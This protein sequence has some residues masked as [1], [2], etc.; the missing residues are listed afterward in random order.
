MAPSHIVGSLLLLGGTAWADIYSR[1]AASASCNETYNSHSIPGC[2]TAFGFPDCV[3]GP[4][5]NNTVCDTTAYE[6]IN[7]T[8][9]VN[10]AIPRLGLPAYQWWQEALHG[11]AFSFPDGPFSY[12]GNYSS[13]TSF[14]QPILMGA[15]FDDTLIR[16]VATVV[17]TEARAFSNALR[18]G[19]DYWT[20]NINPFK[21]PRWGRGQETPGEDPFHISKYVQELVYGLQGGTDPKYK[22]VVATCKHFVGYDLEAADGVTRRHE[23]NAQISQQDLSEYYTP[24]FQSCVRDSNVGAVMCSYNSVNGVP[25]CASSYFL[26]TILRDH[27]NW[28]AEQQWV[29][30]DCDAV[31]DIWDT[32]NYTSSPEQAAADA[33]NA[34]TGAFD[35]GLFKEATI[36]QALTRLYSSLVRLGYFDPAEV[37]PYRSLGWSD[38]NTPYA[39]ELAL[40]AAQEGIVLLKNDGVLPLNIG[41]GTTVAMLGNWTNATTQMQGNYAGFAPYLISP[42]NATKQLGAQMTNDPSAAD[43][44]IFAGGIDNNI[45]AESLDRLNITWPADQ[46]QTISDLA[47]YGKPMVVLQMGGGQVDSSF[48]K[49]NSNISALV[50]GGYPGQSGGVALLDVL[51]GK[52]AP[53]G[54][55]PLT[56]YPGEYVDEVNMTDM[57]LRPSSTSP[58][59]TYKWYTGVPV[60]EFGYGLHYTNFT[61]DIQDLSSLTYN[62]SDIVSTCQKTDT[63]YLDL[64]TLGDELR[65]NVKNV[66]STTS[67]YVA[68]VFAKGT[69][70]PSPYPNKSL[71]S[72]TRLFDIAPNSTASTEL[73]LTLGALSRA[74][75][76]GNKIL[77]PGQYTLELDLEPLSSVNF[78]LTGEAMTLEDWPQA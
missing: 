41:A 68:L 52:V 33:L 49:N 22:R 15:A 1:Q 8:V 61:A 50:W 62:I 27:W 76:N 31:E 75:E 71:V 14:P 43:V 57:S 55:L 67:D 47:T 44:I 77:Y 70:G 38:V 74:D 48:I 4:L 59:R 73:T 39:Q 65:V 64:C 16:D 53:A 23:F 20:P 25:T 21:D 3:N 32:H 46:I 10:P 35:Q 69:Y 5:S 63:R 42:W 51:T 56:Q 13:A 29:T 11:V 24:S 26:Q 66:G 30:S 9:N 7:L 34:G 12:S 36:D 17:S 6:K 58:G 54:R 78:T 28:T 2:S 37:Q 45:E 40:K 60:Y 18:S 19:L 72:Y